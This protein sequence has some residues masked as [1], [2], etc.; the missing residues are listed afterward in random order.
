MEI[1]KNLDL[2]SL[3]QTLNRVPFALTLSNVSTPDEPLIFMNK[4]FRKMTGCTKEHL[5]QN[6][7]F[8]Q[9]EFTNE[10]AR[11]EINLALAERRRTQVVLKNRRMDGT[12]FHN[13][14]RLEFVGPY[15]GFPEL[16]VGTQFD[17]GQGDPD[18]Q[19]TE[20]VE[21]DRR[22]V[23]HTAKNRGLEIMLERR[24]I[25]SAS[26]VRLLESWCILKGLRAQ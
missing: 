18:T 2:G 9:A 4:A 23:F 15:E 6:C 12:M 22:D 11:A 16:A 10:E 25:A 13:L 21:G 17:L 5:G 20:S 26:A 7:R 8:L 14:L 3:E 19:I 1:E 24:R